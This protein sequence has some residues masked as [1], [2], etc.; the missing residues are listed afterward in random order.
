M[1]DTY[2]MR[3]QS[4]VN[5]F[6]TNQVSLAALMIKSLFSLVAISGRTFTMCT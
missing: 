1:C 6:L 3:L 5:L 4:L 2:M